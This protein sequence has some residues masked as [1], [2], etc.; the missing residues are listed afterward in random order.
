MTLSLIEQGKL[1]KEA[2]RQMGFMTAGAKNQILKKMADALITRQDT[3]LQANQ[4]DLEAARNKNISNALL[5]RLMLNPDR[6]KDMANGLLAIMALPDPV[7][8][9]ESMWKGMQDIEIGRVRV[10]LGVIGIIYEARPNVTADAAGLCVK[11]GNAVILRG[12]GDA[13]LSNQSIVAVLSIA[14]KEAGAPEGAI[15]LVQDPGRESAR[16]LMQMREYLDVLIPRGGA[17]LIREVVENSKVPVIETGTGNCHIYIDAQADLDM[18]KRIIVNAKTQRPG[19]CNAAET[20]LVHKNCAEAFLP[21]AAEALETKGVELRGCPRSRGILQHIKEAT[22]EDYE[23]EYQDLILAVRVVD[24]LADAMDHIRR[25]GTRHSETIVTQDYSNARVF[26]KEV[27][28]ACVYV[29]ASTRFTDGF[30]FGFGAEIG[31]STQKLHAR[32][33]MGLRELTT[34]KYII[35]GDG[36]IRK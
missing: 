18:G 23:Q 33:P 26:L 30:Q 32:G 13:F 14:A 27:D 3:I 8:E 6:I 1:A 7:G 28:A 24:S 2:A 9:V 17:G 19:V 25:F 11:T 15:Q 22:D 34:I 12:G 10:P 31:I 21:A 5:D 20:L 35:Y 29:N 16:Q 4:R 36:Q